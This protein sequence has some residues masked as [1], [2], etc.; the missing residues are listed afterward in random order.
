MSHDV[1]ITFADFSVACRYRSASNSEIIISL[2]FLLLPPAAGDKVHASS[3]RMSYF[4][5]KE[6]VQFS[7]LSRIMDKEFTHSCL[8]TR[9]K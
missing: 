1:S 5:D 7:L 6:R 8:A 3:Q 9:K 2:A 4:S